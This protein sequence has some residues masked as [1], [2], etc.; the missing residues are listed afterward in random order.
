MFWLLSYAVQGLQNNR[1]LIISRRHLLI[2]NADNKLCEN[3]A[4]FIFI[5]IVITSLVGR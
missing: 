1:L 5:G 3:L 2:V 4:K